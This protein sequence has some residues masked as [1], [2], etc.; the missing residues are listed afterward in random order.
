MEQQPGGKS[1][2]ERLQAHLASGAQSFE[3]V[4]GEYFSQVVFKADQTETKK[5]DNPAPDK[6]IG[7]VNGQQGRKKCP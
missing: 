3:I 4:S 6:R 5:S 2:N 7:K 1:G